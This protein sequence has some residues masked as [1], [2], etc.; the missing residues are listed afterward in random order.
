MLMQPSMIH[1]L[2]ML[3]RSN[4]KRI[5]LVGTLC[6]LL[7]CVTNLLSEELL[8]R[9]IYL[10]FMS[11]PP[12]YCYRMPG[13]SLPDIL[14]IDP[15]RGK[16]I[17]FHETSCKSYKHKKIVIEKRQ[18]C[19]IESAAKLNENRSVYVLF[20]SPG[21][22]RYEGTESD[23]LIKVLL[24]YK[25]VH[26]LRVNFDNYT[27]NTPIEN[28]YEEGYIKYSQYAQSH[29][30]DLL[31]YVTL[32][33][34]G[35]IYLDLDVIVIRSFSNLAENFA[36]AESQSAVAA[37]VLSFNDSELGHDY[38]AAC[39]YDLE[40]NYKYDDWG[41]NG[42]G[43]ITRLLQDLC[44]TKKVSEMVNKN[45]NGFKVYPPSYFYPIAWNKWKMYFQ[46]ENSDEVFKLSQF[47]YTIH[48]WNKLSFR[49]RLPHSSNASYVWFARKFCPQVYQTSRGY[50]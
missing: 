17:F 2:I 22:I 36:G 35:G 4:K 25:N 5:A 50:F 34:Y 42:P 46:E 1:T 27:K 8:L 14:E 20:T 7:I 31:R 38:A 37:G 10:Y 47:S 49:E 30:S 13:E 15:P 48:V 28:L 39:L 19:A 21:I 33:K 3:G 24:T 9:K 43:V 44:D 45:C 16:S 29:M 32:W 23:N 26:L 12:L 18:A 41:N 6:F 40:S 11:N